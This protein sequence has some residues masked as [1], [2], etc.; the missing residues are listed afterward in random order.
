MEQMTPKTRQSNMELLRLV[1]MFMIVVYHTVYYRLYNYRTESP[2]FSSLMIVLHIGVPL[3]VLISGY[4]GIK[5]SVKGIFKLY[6][7]LL[8]YNLVLYG[9]RIVSGD[10]TF[11]I[12]EFMRLWLPFSWGRVLWFFKVYIMLYISAPVVNYLKEKM[13]MELLLIS[14]FLTFYFGWFA[15]HPSLSNGKN[16]VNFV[17]LYL[18]GNMLHKMLVSWKAPS[19]K[20]RMTLAFWYIGLTIAVGLILAYPNEHVQSIGKRLFW[21][22]N[23][24]ILLLMSVL[25]FCIFAT[26]N[27]KS[28]MVNWWAGS[29]FAVYMIHENYWFPK[30]NWYNMIDLQYNSMSGTHF[31]AILLAECATLFISAILIDKIRAFVMQ[32]V[33]PLGDY[34]QKKLTNAYLWVKIKNNRRIDE[35][36]TKK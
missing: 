15:Q 5:P 12:R 16:I 3:F 29:V 14:G 7:I 26:F 22:Y 10:I 19:G 32:P 25:F 11:S 28:K 34:L 17:F 8:F 31:S 30:D 1:A 18:L 6:A 27:F 24:P 4:F 33:M 21:G 36:L 23:S 9:Y 20:K 35:F 13:E 2:V